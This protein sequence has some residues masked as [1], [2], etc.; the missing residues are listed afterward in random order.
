MD[1]KNTKGQFFYQSHAILNVLLNGEND[2]L[3]ITKA[4][5]EAGE[6]KATSSQYIKKT[7]KYV[8]EMIDW[9]LVNLDVAT[10]K[11]KLIPATKN[12]DELI[13]MYDSAWHVNKRAN[14][15]K[16]FRIPALKPRVEA[17]TEAVVDAGKESGKAKATK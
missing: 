8:Q 9:Q 7:V 6:I 5:V 11:V 2:I 3:G 13:S 12:V 16:A 14:N 4:L 17:V 15:P 1:I 10:G